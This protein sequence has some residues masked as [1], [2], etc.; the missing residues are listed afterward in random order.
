MESGENALY[1]SHDKL[2]LHDVDLLAAVVR[3]VEKLRLVDKANV[4]FRSGTSTQI[5]VYKSWLDNGP[6]VGNTADLKSAFKQFCIS[7]SQRWSADICAYSLR[8]NA[9]RCSRSTR[10]RLEHAV[11][12]FIPTAWLSSFG[13]V[14]HNA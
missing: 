11:R 13:A 9:Q 3:L 10:C 7:P 5:V 2:V 4:N 14:E 12:C 6:W 8:R 1:G